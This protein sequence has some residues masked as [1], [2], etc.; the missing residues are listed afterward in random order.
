MTPQTSRKNHSQL[1]IVAA[2]V[3]A[4]AP[5]ANAVGPTT[6][7]ADAAAPASQPVTVAPAMNAPVAA[8]PPKTN[9]PAVVPPTTAP[10]TLPTIVASP[11]TAPAIAASPSTAP[12]TAPATQTAYAIPVPA[13]AKPLL[14]QVAAAY[15]QSG[16]LT[17]RG[18]I[19]ADF[20]VSGLKKTDQIAFDSAADARG[21]FVF[22]LGEEQVI[23]ASADR[24]VIFY[25]QRNQYLQTDPIAAAAPLD[26][27][28]ADVRALL[29][30]QDPSLLLALV[31]RP[32]D[33]LLAGQTS[34][35]SV[36]DTTINGTAC[37]TLEMTSKRRIT[38]VA[39]DPQT[40]LLRRWTI[41]LEPGLAEQGAAGI[42]SATVTINYTQAAPGRPAPEAVAFNLP[43]DA[44][45]YQPASAD[46]MGETASA[47][48]QLGG[49]TAPDFTL[50]RLDGQK[51]VRL[52][53]L[54]GKVVVLDFWATWCPPCVAGMPHLNRLYAQH[55]ADGLVVLGLNQHEDKATVADFIQNKGISFTILLDDGK[56]AEHYFVT[57]IPQTVVVG[58][59]GLVR[60]VVT[61]F[62]PD[63]AEV[64]AKAVE[65]AME[66]D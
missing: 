14:E 50:P 17:T 4:T 35:R 47:E 55:K 64:V 32:A 40:H 49:K 13:D 31:D 41:D 30:D 24:T 33:A 34:I 51:D 60:K 6:T 23:A 1:W 20:D 37:P 48:Q 56:T 46:L 8:V 21:A 26:K 63:L 27:L 52:S 12:S 19:S 7:P 44:R 58:K 3:L 39:V 66:E 16:G 57:G 42:K 9:P 22:K 62:S 38:R 11:A 53:D 10:T 61:G 43:R 5:L 18:T 15:A 45:E 29:I 25:A 65:A 36:S 2:A 54:K 59:D 28:P